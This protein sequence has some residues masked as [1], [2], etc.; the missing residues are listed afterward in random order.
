[1]VNFSCL[2]QDNSQISIFCPDFSL[3]FQSLG[4]TAFLASQLRHVRLSPSKPNSIPGV[5]ALLGVVPHSINCS[6]SLCFFGYRPVITFDVFFPH[7]THL[8]HHQILL[9]LHTKHFQNPA[10]TALVQVPTISSCIVVSDPS[11]APQWNIFT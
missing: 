3:E 4:S 5:P 9:A 6:S 2:C 10:T 8:T 7:T 11:L 1:M